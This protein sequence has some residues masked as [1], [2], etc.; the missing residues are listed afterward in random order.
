MYTL[1]R[2]Q[3]HPTLNTLLSNLNVLPTYVLCSL[4]SCI[5]CNWL[6]SLAL[7][8]SGQIL[9]EL[10]FEAFKAAKQEEEAARKEEEAAAAAA[11][12]QAQEVGQ[13]LGRWWQQG[14]G[15]EE[16]GRGW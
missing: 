8:V 1:F 11:A 12:H 10:Y 7:P 3:S 4:L 5:C 9:D 2:V 15:F 14:S 13:G 6:L 16:W